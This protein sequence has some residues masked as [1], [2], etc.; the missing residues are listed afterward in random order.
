MDFLKLIRDQV[1]QYLGR[2]LTEDE[3]ISFERRMKD[4]VKAIELFVLAAAKKF[5]RLLHDIG[6]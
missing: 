2:E 1:T 6:H 3:L 4:E 5:V